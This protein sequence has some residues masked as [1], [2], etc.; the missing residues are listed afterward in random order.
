MSVTITALRSED[1]D[2]WL[3]LWHGYLD[4]YETEL[5]EAVTRSTFERLTVGSELHGAIA[6]DGEGRA[7]GIVHWLAHPATW[8]ASTYCYLED[9]FVAQDARVSGTGTALIQHVRAWA[10]AAGSSKVY[11]LTGET[12]LVARGLYDQVADRSGLIQYE[13]KL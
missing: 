6:R 8:T 11:W 4:F 13:I 10:T 3:E 2:E 5:D 1:H 12:N 7:V 9:L